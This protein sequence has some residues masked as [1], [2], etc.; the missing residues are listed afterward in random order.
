MAHRQNLPLQ[1]LAC[2]EQIG[3]SGRR[4]CRDKQIIA[5]KSEM[6]IVANV[7]V[8]AIVGIA[9]VIVVNVVDVVV[10]VVVVCVVVFVVVA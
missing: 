3:G 7:V 8:V 2:L 9:V 5:I 6:I 10:V 1:V 4:V